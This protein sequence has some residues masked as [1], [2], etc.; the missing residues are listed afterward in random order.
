MIERIQIRG[1][2]PHIDHVFT[3]PNKGPWTI[4]GASRTG[5][6]TAANAITG[7]L[8]G[9]CLDGS[10]WPGVG[11]SRTD[12]D[13]HEVLLTCTTGR[14]FG[15]RCNATLAALHGEPGQA[16]RVCSQAELGARLGP[17]A[18]VDLG[19]TIA[20]PSYWLADVERL[21]TTLSRVLPGPT[22]ADLL[23]AELLPGEP[24]REGT[25][26]AAIGAAD[27]SR[28]A[29]KA[30]NEAAG[31]LN[32]ARR[33]AGELVPPVQPDPEHV[34]AARQAQQAVEAS[35]AAATAH[36]PILAAWKVAGA[37][38]AARLAEQARWDAAQPVEPTVVAPLDY[39][40]TATEQAVTR[41]EDEAATAAQA[42]AAVAEHERAVA[43]YAQR[44]QERAAW[45]SRRAALVEPSP[46]APER[47]QEAAVEEVAAHQAWTALQA[48]DAAAREAFRGSLHG[49]QGR[50]REIAMWDRQR[51][52]LVEP[53][54]TG[55]PGVTGSRCERAA[56][57]RA[58]YDRAV[59]ALGPR[60]EPAPAPTQPT[61][62]DMTAAIERHR[63]AVEDRGAVAA[64]T[65]EWVTYRAALAALGDCPAELPDPG[66]APDR[67]AAEEA[68][69]PIRTRL[70]TARVLVSPLTQAA[71]PWTTYRQRVA[72]RGTRPED[73]P[74]PGPEPIAPEVLTLSAADRQILAAADAYPAALARHE[75]D[76][77]ARTARVERLA[78]AHAAAVVA[79]DRAK[80]VLHLVRTAPGRA[81][82]GKIGA[83]AQVGS[84]Q[85]RVSAEGALSVWIDGRPPSAASTGEL[86]V[87][88]AAWRHALRVA[89]GASWAPL[90]V[91]GVQDLAGP[92]ASVLESIPAPILML[93]TA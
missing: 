64:L 73:A 72:D 75:A 53:A 79:A 78:A 14:Q 22:A 40:I 88:S 54:V 4:T 26:K 3:F 87:C 45:T 17:I 49:H 55:C 35:R 34:E 63:R 6:T 8:W 70:S 74:D 91:D 84:V 68:A 50:E 76:V 93:R 28:D 21:A 85:L 51:A 52:A 89:V 29:T 39:E 13:S 47:A 19:L 37:Q 25:T 5:K 9:R 11:R 83:L 16:P 77:L 44:A 80:R 67:Q 18:D 66:P 30:A 32:E 7:A 46:Q 27:A 33:G 36:A 90:I 43:A 15:R 12:C 62:V 48:K 23:A 82:Q 81:L 20:S 86:L 60:P 92:D 57:A 38:H 42:L 24:T 65:A 59:E 58:T 71:A 69:T 41:W 10:T 2:G 56:D 61:P 31:A 1:I